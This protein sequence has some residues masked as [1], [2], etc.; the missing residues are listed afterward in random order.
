[1]CVHVK[2]QLSYNREMFGNL[3]Q[4]YMKQCCGQNKDLL[5]NQIPT[6][7]VESSKTGS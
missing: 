1:M 2:C 7:A 3:G 4:L 6:P 5:G